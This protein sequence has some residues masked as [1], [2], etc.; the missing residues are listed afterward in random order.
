[1]TGPLIALLG[2]AARG[3]VN[4]WPPAGAQVVDRLVA[5]VNKEPIT[6]FELQR[7]AAPQVARVMRDTADPKERDDALREVI[8]KTVDQLVD[9][10]LV[11]DQ[12]K[13]LEL[14]VPLERV[15]EH[16]KKIRE[17]NGW[18][19]DEFAT[20]LKSLG[21]ASISDYRRHTEQEMLKSRVIGIKVGARVKVDEAEVERAYR[22]QLTT[23]GAVVERRVAHILLRVAEGA[24]EAADAAAKAKL[25]EIRARIVA[26]T[27]SFA[28]AAKQSSED[29]TRAAGGDLGWTA[30]GDFVP[31]FETVA[32]ATP[33]GEISEPFRT[34][35][36]WHLVPTSEV[37]ERKLTTTED[38][39]TVKCQIRYQLRE[40]Q[41][42]KLYQQWVQGLRSDAF[43]EVKDLGLG[44]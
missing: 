5:I 23:G 17:A 14:T 28:D 20:A 15:D 39:Q 16:L 30:R 26:G 7:A 36:G 19:E 35:F 12:A 44:S 2:T 3:D 31:E 11:Y 29:G 41:M 24:G 4:P 6:L 40:T 22:E 10:I 27:I 21:F 42:E 8:T 43:V 34:Q 38:E 1:M 13:K 25:A 32:F 37:R 33:E 9:D 18:S